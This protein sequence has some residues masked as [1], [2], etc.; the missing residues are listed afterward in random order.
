MITKHNTLRFLLIA[1]VVLTT[2]FTSYA[3]LISRADSAYNQSNYREALSL[4]KEVASTQGTSSEL[5]YNIGNTEFR[6]GNIGQAVLAYERALRIDP[7]NV[8]ARTNLDFVKRTITGLPDD[9]STFLSNLHN[10]IVAKAAPDSWAWIAFGFFALTL[11]CAALYMFSSNIAARK[12]GFFGGF[13][14]FILF[15]YASVIAWQSSH[16]INDH[17]TV[18]VTAPGARLTT[19]PG[20]TNKD[21]SSKSAAVPEGTCLQVVD[22]VSTPDDPMSSVWYNIRLSNSTEAWINGAEVE[23]I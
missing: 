2:G 14:V 19:T 21:I 22:S 18:V 20:K 1:V 9:G 13:V 3:S 16:G 12:T 4:Y 7:S 10:G 23:R 8:D 5:L 17:E 15:I 6:L 11:G